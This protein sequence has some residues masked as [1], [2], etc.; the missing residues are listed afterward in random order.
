MGREDSIG[1]IG[2]LKVM[3]KAF[4]CFGLFTFCVLAIY[5]GIYNGVSYLV[6]RRIC[7][8]ICKEITECDKAFVNVRDNRTEIKTNSEIENLKAGFDSLEFVY[9]GKS[10]YVPCG[11]GDDY[12]IEFV[13]SESG[14]K[15]FIRPAKDGDGLLLIQEDYFSISY[16]S[17]ESIFS[18]VGKYGMK[19]QYH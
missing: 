2:L 16:E 10:V 3:F 17:R 5:C 7:H 4:F 12:S 11:F 19:D 15:I 9:D 13:N 1:V 14:E 6:E 8:S 18:I